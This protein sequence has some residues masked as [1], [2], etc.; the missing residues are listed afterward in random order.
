MARIEQDLEARIR[1]DPHQAQRVV[2]TL[3]EASQ[4]LSP[5]D[6]GLAGVQEIGD[7]G[8]LTGS[9]TGEQL[10]ELS[11]RSEIEEIVSDSEVHIHTSS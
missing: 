9:V 11:K 7:S 10:L 8:I 3:T 5:A 2:I 1:K 4:H 6:L